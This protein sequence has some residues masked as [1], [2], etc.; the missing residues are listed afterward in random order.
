MQLLSPL[1]SEHQ[2]LAARFK[3]Y[4]GWQV[5]AVY[6]SE[7]E[8]MQIVRGA[9][10]ITDYAFMH[11]II[12]RGPD[13]FLLLQRALSRDLSRFAP[14]RAF[15]ALVLD[16]TG[17]VVEDTTVL[18]TQPDV[19][20]LMCRGRFGFRDPDPNC[21]LSARCVKDWLTTAGEDLRVCVYV[22]GA[23]LIS[24][25]GPRSQQVLVKSAP[26]DTL[27][28]FELVQTHLDGIPVL[29]SRTGYSGELGY[30]ILVWPEYAVALWRTI[31]RLGRS[32]GLAPYGV[33]VLEMISLEKGYLSGPDF[34]AGSTPLELGLHWAVDF[35]KPDF[36]G[37]DALFARRDEG[38]RTRLIGFSLPDNRF[39]AQRGD[40]LLAG[41]KLVGEVTSGAFS[42]TLERSL[43]RGWVDV[44][45]ARAG[46]VLTLLTGDARIDVEVADGY[47]WYD[48]SKSR[49]GYAEGSI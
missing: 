11:H 43:A 47:C 6:A 16:A 9:V 34:Y 39:T 7:R 30:D 2:R 37:R 18:W 19:F 45:C 28:A 17:R 23:T 44:D 10:G 26:V 13:A 32:C 25:Q 41:D 40:R 42:P 21:L 33:N 35:D 48:P 12:V 38:V 49:V 15:F 36:R 8:E 20:V 4:F 5:P 46:A 14:G 29:I 3:D 1:H 31:E 22:S 24:V 27:C